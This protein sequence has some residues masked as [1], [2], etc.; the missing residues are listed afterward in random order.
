MPRG[1]KRDGAGRKSHKEKAN[2][3]PPIHPAPVPYDPL[4]ITQARKL[5][6]L[7]ATDTE[8][9]DFF[10]IDTATL[11]RWKVQFPDFCEATKGGKYAAD[12]RVERSLYQRAVGYTFDAVKIIAVKGEVHKVPYREHVPPDTA[13][14][15]M[16]LRNRRKDQWRDRHEYEHGKPGDFDKLDAAGLRAAISGRLRLVGSGDSSSNDPGEQGDL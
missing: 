9:A 14:A 8:L 13:A 1:G 6:D 16:W 4:I 12:D 3:P 7:G 11:Y 10:E 15:S 5:S 2:L